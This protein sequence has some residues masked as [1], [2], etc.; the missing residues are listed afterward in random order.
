MVQLWGDQSQLLVLPI[1]SKLYYYC[2]VDTKEDENSIEK[3]GEHLLFFLDISA[4]MNHDE[5]VIFF[6]F[7][8]ILFFSIF[9]LFFLLYLYF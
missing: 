7:F 5:K 8:S 9:F 3:K 6:L 1:D 4:S 2:T